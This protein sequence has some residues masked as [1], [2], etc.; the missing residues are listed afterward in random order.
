VGLGAS[1]AR[2]LEVAV[3][4]T[5]ER[6]TQPGAAPEGRRRLSLPTGDAA[7]LESLRA[8]FRRLVLASRAVPPAGEGDHR[9][10][11]RRSPVAMWVYD[12]ETLR[13]LEVNEA[14]LARF[15]RTREEVL[16]I[17]LRDLPLAGPHEM[18]CRP[19]AAGEDGP[20]WVG[21]PRQRCAESPPRLEVTTAEVDFGGR[22]AVLAIAREVAPASSDACPGHHAG[23]RAAAEAAERLVTTVAGHGSVL[24]SHLGAHPLA[25]HVEAMQRAAQSVLDALRDLLAARPVAGAQSA[26]A[27]SP[28]PA[29]SG[30]GRHGPAVPGGST[31]GAEGAAPVV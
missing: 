13:V 21:V 17:P 12:R 19:P 7:V 24:A 4:R 9:E 14:A 8:D 18:A 25:A 10:L 3:A 6:A 15:G 26:A 11:F 30:A 31:S 5:E 23:I 16:G 1:P 22:P 29:A 2:G 27:A 20:L 28:H